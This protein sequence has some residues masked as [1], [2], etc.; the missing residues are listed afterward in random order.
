MGDAEPHPDCG[1]NQFRDA[2]R[3]GKNVVVPMADNLPA[4]SLESRGAGSVIRDLGSVLPTI[5]FDS[6]PRLAA[7]EVEDVRSDDELSG[8]ARSCGR[9]EAP[10]FPFGGRGVRS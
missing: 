8:P 7:G 4:L 9:K 3:I 10:K 1:K 6:Q 2:L 5:E